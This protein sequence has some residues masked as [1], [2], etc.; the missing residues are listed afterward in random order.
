[1]SHE[2]AASC[3][4]ARIGFLGWRVLCKSHFSAQTQSYLT[5]QKWAR[6]P[7]VCEHMWEERI[8][9][10]LRYWRK[11]LV[12]GS[13]WSP[14]PLCVIAPIR[15][16]RR[17]MASQQLWTRII[18][19]SVYF[20]VMSNAMPDVPGEEGFS[21]EVSFLP[22]KYS[23]SSIFFLMALL[24]FKLCFRFVSYLKHL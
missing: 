13:H 4:P 18:F 10:H 17:R 23:Y 16:L 2:A 19:T 14:S 5:L 11:V 22:I 20:F 24:V 3:L 7:K 21:A 15:L 1:M 6:V 9:Q 8:R 12:S